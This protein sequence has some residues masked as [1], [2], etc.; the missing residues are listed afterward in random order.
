MLIS[1]SK[2][3]GAGEGADVGRALTAY[4]D[5]PAVVKTS[6]GSRRL[7]VA[8]DP[9]PE[10]LLGRA[11]L[12]RAS[13]RNLPFV[14]RYSSAVLSSARDDI[15]VAAFN[16][17][18]PELRWQVDAALRLFFAVSFAGLPARHQPPAYVTTHTHTGRLEVNIAVSRG[19]LT[20]Q[21]VLRSINPHPP[22]RGSS[23]LW[24]ALQDTLN[25]R[26][27]WAD[28][29]DPARARELVLPDWELKQAAAARAGLPPQPDLRQVF[30]ERIQRAIADRAVPGRA[31]LLEILAEKR[32]ELGFSVVATSRRAITVAAPDCG[33]EHPVRLEGPLYRATVG[34]AFSQ[35]GGK[36]IDR[37]RAERIQ[38]M[39]T[40]PPRLQRAWEQRALENQ[41]RFGI[42][43]DATFSCDFEELLGA[44][45]PRPVLIP[46]RHHRL[47]A[48]RARHRAEG[49]PT[50][51]VD[52]IVSHGPAPARHGPPDRAR[53][54]GSGMNAF[55]A[56]AAHGAAVSVRAGGVISLALPV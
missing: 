33:P 11:D 13:V 35:P 3:T 17:G 43:D 37:L 46:M 22:R 19:V 56:M 48:T 39:R 20:P 36:D 28:P 16:K 9:V 2:H 10:I 26:F 50:H 45:P 14:H 41:A 42:G 34:T 21:G 30:H 18:A 7:L 55:T 29:G 40:A 15:E 38:Q 24:A 53:G 32:A 27:G 5:A 44:V 49:T 1:F 51:E 54:E 47:T 31:A 23:E 6:P 52:E 25:L 4:M 12:L 8:R